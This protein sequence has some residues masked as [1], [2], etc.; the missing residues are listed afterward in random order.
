MNNQRH[1]TLVLSVLQ[2][3]AFASIPPIMVGYMLATQY[4]VYQSIFNIII[5]NFIVFLLSIPIGIQASK[6]RQTSAA[7]VQD[8]LGFKGNKITILG[9]LILLI[10]WFALNIN[11]IGKA[12]LDITNIYLSYDIYSLSPLFNIVIGSFIIY[13]VSRGIT[14]LKNFTKAFVILFFVTIV[15]NLF[16]QLTLN[17]TKVVDYGSYSIVIPA[18]L[19]VVACPIGQIFD[20]PT[21]HRFA[22]SKRSSITSNALVFLI[23]LPLVEITGSLL[24]MCSNSSNII[25]SLI[26]QSLP[27]YVLIWNAIFIT[28]SVCSIDNINLYVLAVNTEVLM[29]RIAFKYRA[30]IIGL[31]AVLF[32]LTNVLDNF[33]GLLNNIVVVIA[34]ILA[35]L[36][37]R[38]LT[39]LPVNTRVANIALLI[40]IVIGFLNNLILPSYNFPYVSA[41]ISTVFFYL[42]LN[43][44][45]SKR[46]TR[47][48]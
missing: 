24:Y 28:V 38:A 29:P 18:L 6:D 20:L 36:I 33:M 4:G 44:L 13:I 26:D 5:G 8:V 35:L 45:I 40:G 3:G 37:V 21:F 46:F 7:Q 48:K 1:S 17:T 15:V 34:S 39:S 14:V 22:K 43:F 31:V 11:L 41:S 32:S 16:A 27:S 47:K 23:F 42:I 19:F 2:I 12:I 10:G 9:L 30:Y 25:S